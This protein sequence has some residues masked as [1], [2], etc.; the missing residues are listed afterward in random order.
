M[1]GRNWRD[2]EPS[3]ARNAAALVG[4]NQLDWLEL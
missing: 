3:L 4:L 1:K 2:G